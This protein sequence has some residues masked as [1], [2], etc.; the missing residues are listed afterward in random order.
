[1]SEDDEPVI[2]MAT[3]ALSGHTVSDEEHQEDRRSESSSEEELECCRECQFA[4]EEDQGWS[5]EIR[6][7]RRKQS[8]TEAPSEPDVEKAPLEDLANTCKIV[9]FVMLPMI[10]RQLGTYVGR[11]GKK[12]IDGMI[13]NFASDD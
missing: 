9:L 1:M 4:C 8:G 5:A 13:L 10:G 6:R 12:R 3:L 2:N 7:Q 11:K